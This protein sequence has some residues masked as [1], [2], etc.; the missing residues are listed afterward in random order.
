MHHYN[1][2]HQPPAPVCKA[3]IIAYAE[4]LL[5]VPEVAIEEVLLLLDSGADGGCL[6]PHIIEELESKRGAKLP[7][8]RQPYLGVDGTPDECDVIE[9]GIEAKDLGGKW[10]IEFAIL[11]TD[12]ALIGRDLLNKLSILHN[13]PELHWKVL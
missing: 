9:L 11:P 1:E 3:R 6:P 8:T 2:N 13:G 12:I 7:Y 10:T 5:N 4:P